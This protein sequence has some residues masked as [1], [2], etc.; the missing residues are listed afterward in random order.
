MYTYICEMKLEPFDLMASKSM[1]FEQFEVDL[2]IL[3][4]QCNRFTYSVQFH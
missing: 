4:M 3:C 1:A 2:H